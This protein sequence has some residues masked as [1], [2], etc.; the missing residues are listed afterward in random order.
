MQD[1][2]LRFNL[3]LVLRNLSTKQAE[4][5]FE[6]LKSYDLL[7]CKKS[8]FHLKLIEEAHT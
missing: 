5:I 3:G 2:N 6:F 1:S 4:E 7:Y 8:V